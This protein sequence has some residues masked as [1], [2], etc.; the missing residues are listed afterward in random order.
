MLL[1]PRT[2]RLPEARFPNTPILPLRAELVQ[3]NNMFHFTLKKLWARWREALLTGSITRPFKS[4]SHFGLGQHSTS[5]GRIF[6]ETKTQLGKTA[7]CPQSRCG[8]LKPRH[9]LSFMSLWGCNSH[10]LTFMGGFILA[11]GFTAIFMRDTSPRPVRCNH[12]DL[13]GE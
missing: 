3:V 9:A 12:S 13:A 4:L 8:F 2:Q 7:W 10:H 1:I 11:K 6:P 5:S